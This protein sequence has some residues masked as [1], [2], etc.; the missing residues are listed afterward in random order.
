M[1]ARILLIFLL[2][3]S[4]AS[5][6]QTP[7]TPTEKPRVGRVA[8][9]Y[10]PPSSGKEM[11]EAYCASCHGID[12]RGDGPAA[13]ALKNP[14]PDLTLIRSH[15]RGQFPDAHIAEIIRGD[16]NLPAHGSKDMPVWGRVLLAVSDHHPAE[17]QQRIA[18]LV[19]YIE[20]LQR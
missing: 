17:V 12:G 11:Y 9:P 2:V 16:I 18:N 20:S 15:N 14:V 13:P 19:L 4:V 6:A 5:P 8:A 1:L 10:T 3:A 7:Q